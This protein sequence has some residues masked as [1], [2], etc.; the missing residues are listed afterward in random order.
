M[1]ENGVSGWI[2][3]L[4]P[5]APMSLPILMLFTVA[6]VLGILIIMPVAPSVV[7]FLALPLMS[8]AQATGHSSTLILM[9]LAMASGNCY[10]LPLDTIPLITYGSG[11][12]SMLDMPKS[13][14]PLQIY[15][16][17]A[18]TLVLWASASVLHIF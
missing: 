16:G 18:M 12:Y 6:L 17:A 3:S 13:T 5:S 1:E 10:L 11:Y 2:A 15:V 9:T 14:L 7:M 8:L 4:F